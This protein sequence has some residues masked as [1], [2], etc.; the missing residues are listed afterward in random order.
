MLNFCGCFHKIVIFFITSL[1]GSKLPWR[2]RDWLDQGEG[3]AR[4]PPGPR[5]RAAW[6]RAHGT[7]GP[8]SRAAG[9]RRRPGQPRVQGLGAARGSR[10]SPARGKG[11]GVEGGREVWVGRRIEEKQRTTVENHG[12]GSQEK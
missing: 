9:H 5:G 6:P 3:G 11:H 10:G 7:V 1:S 12:E 8:A 2:K 4:P